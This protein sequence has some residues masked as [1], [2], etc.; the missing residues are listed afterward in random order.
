[1]ALLCL[2]KCAHALLKREN[3]ILENKV[4]ER[5]KELAEKNTDI[6]SSIEYAKRIQEVILP[7]KDQIFSKFNNAFILYK[8]KDIV[9]GDFYWYGN[10]NGFKIFAV[11]DCTGHGVPGAFMSM[12]GHN[13]FESGGN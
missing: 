9:S 12:I 7:A 6:T 8:P 2:F 13:I 11:V 10:K 5:T 1:M 3:K 4:A